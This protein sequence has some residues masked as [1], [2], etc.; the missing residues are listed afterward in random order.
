MSMNSGDYEDDRVL[1]KFDR[2]PV[3]KDFTGVVSRTKQSFKRD[4]DIN[5]ILGKYAKGQVVDH[6]A[7]WEGSFGEFP[8]MDFREAMELT[9]QAQEMFADLP[10]EVRKRFAN[11]PGLFLE[12]TQE[13][14]DKGELKNLEELRRLKLARPAPAPEPTAVETR[15]AEIEADRQ[16][17]VVLARKAIVEPP[18]SSG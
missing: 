6:L 16:A 3:R 14:N 5:V 11:D 13:V 4:C 1:G 10:S 9:R 15:I 12:F 17:R 7:K 18:E 8:A 2:R